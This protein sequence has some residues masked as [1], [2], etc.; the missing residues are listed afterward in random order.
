M[1]KGTNVLIPP[2]VKRDL[3][4]VR[5]D[6]HEKGMKISNQADLVNALI[7]A[8]RRSPIEAVEAIVRTYWQ[9]E[10]AETPQPPEATR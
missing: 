4:A 8:A 6:L 9:R 1:E 5:A 7:L 2:F 3:D 10:A